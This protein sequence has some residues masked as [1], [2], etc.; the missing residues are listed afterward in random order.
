MATTTE[1]RPAMAK[2][3]ASGTNPPTKAVKIDRS[4]ASKADL[5]ATDQGVSLSEYLSEALK[6]IV[7]RDWGRMLKRV[8]DNPGK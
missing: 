1:A 7:E 2:K 3:K 6:A 8:G 4:I 5:I